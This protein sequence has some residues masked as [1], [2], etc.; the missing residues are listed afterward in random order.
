[1][2]LRSSKPG[3]FT[4]ADLDK[5][6]LA[7][8]Q[9]GALTAMI[10]WYRAVAQYRPTQTEEVRLSMPVLMLWGARDIALSQKMA[11]PSIDRCRDGRLVFY[12]N[13]SHWVQHEEADEVNRQLLNLILT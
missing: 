7:W 3:T 4:P 6:R 2:L 12:D 8:S 9:P 1:M 13:A 11:Q 10:N 5:Y